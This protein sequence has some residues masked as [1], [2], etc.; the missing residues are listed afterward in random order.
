MQWSDEG[1]VLSS[2]AHGE[3]STIVEVLTREHGR[4]LGLVHGGRSKRLRP[5][6]QTG[7]LVRAEWRARLSEHLGKYAV[8]LLEAHAARVL[9]DRAALAG[10]N[11]LTALARLLPEREPHQPLYDVTK[12]VLE[13]FSEGEHWPALLVRWEFA[14]LD[15]LGFGLDLDECAATGTT[16]DL[17]YVSPK[18]GRAVSR[19]AG[20]PYADKLLALPAFLLPG[21]G[22]GA[23]PSDRDVA[24]GFAL[25]SYFF[26]KN[27]WQPRNMTP[28]QVR[29]RLVARLCG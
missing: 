3:T 24:D 17:I 5:V 15:E 2:Q 9:D 26:E 7:N 12:L 1:I 25:T 28:P 4:H 8:E 21:N 10:L 11:T 22:G 6:L 19:G 16:E 27:V 23:S 13:A 29:E 14:L 18:T 20:A